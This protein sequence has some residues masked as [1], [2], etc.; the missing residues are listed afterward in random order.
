MTYPSTLTMSLKCGYLSYFIW[1]T[2]ATPFKSWVIHTAKMFALW[3][4]LISSTHLATLSGEVVFALINLTLLRF[5]L[6]WLDSSFPHFPS[7]VFSFRLDHKFDLMYAK[8]AFVH[9]WGRSFFKSLKIQRLLN[10]LSNSC[11]KLGPLGPWGL[12]NMPLWFF[13]L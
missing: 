8:R 1:T 11:G 13:I 12:N 9:W 4:G 6:S 7:P 3:L 2:T 5:L 10:P